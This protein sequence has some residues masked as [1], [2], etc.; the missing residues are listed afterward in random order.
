MAKTEMKSR[1]KCS[2][3]N[4]EGTQYISCE[5]STEQSKGGDAWFNVAFCNQCGHIH[6]I[7]VK[8]ILS[9]SISLPQMPTMPKI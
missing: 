2:K 3:C 9:P 5:D 4:V 1:P 8:V 7:F 6:G